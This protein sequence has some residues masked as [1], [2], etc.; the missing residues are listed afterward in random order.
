VINWN[1]FK[2]REF[3]QH[4]LPARPPTICEATELADAGGLMSLSV[5]YTERYR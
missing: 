4:A 2:Y 5:S 3:V 1:C